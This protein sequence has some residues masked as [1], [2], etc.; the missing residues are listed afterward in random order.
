MWPCVDPRVSRRLGVALAA[1]LSLGATAL[2]ESPYLYGIHDHDPDPSEFLNRIKAGTGGVGGWVT[3]TVAVGAN[4]NDFSGA[5]FSALANAGHTIICRINYGYFPQGTIPVPALWDAFAIRCKNFVANSTGCNIWLIANETN[6]AVEWP[7]DP[8]NNRFNYISPQDYAVCFRKVY[9]AIKSVRPNDKVIVQALAPWGGPYGPGTF[10]VGGVNY[11]H[12]GVPL[13]WVQYLNQMLTAIAASGPLDGIALHIGSRGYDYEDIHST[14]KVNAGGQNLY[15]SF[16]V[17]KDWIDYGI[18]SSLYHL[19]LYV[20]ECNGLYYWK[21]GGP[22]GE[23]NPEPYKPGW[24]QEIYAEFN[25][26]NQW[27]ATN[28]RPIFRCVNL[29]RWCAYCDGWN[30]DG[31]DNPYKGQ[32]L[33]DLDAAVAQLYRWPTNVIPTNPPAAPTGLTATVGNGRV[34]LTWNPVAFANTYRVKRSTVSGGPYTVIASNLVVTTYNDVSFT[35]GTTYY[36]RVSAVN[37]LGEGPNSAQV[38]ATPTNALPDVVVT[39]ISWTPASPAVGSNVVFAATVRNQG[40]GPTPSGVILGVGFS[41]NGNLV[42]WSGTHTA[43]LAPGAS[44][45]LTANGGPGGINYWTATAGVH[46]VTAHVD[47]VNRFEEADEGNNIATTNLTI[48]APGYAINCG[49]AAAGGFSADAYWSGSANTYSN[50]TAID[51]SGVTNPAPLAV[52]QTERWGNSTYTFPALV[53]GAAYAVRLHWAEISPSVNAPGDRRFHVSINGTQVLTNFD[54]WA[55]AGA[56]FRAVTRTFTTN[57]NSA[58]QIV[59]AFTRG[60]A[61][62]AKIGGIEI[63][64]VAPAPPVL[65]PI[66]NRVINEGELL[67][68]VALAADTQPGSLITDFE[69]FTNG[70]TSVMFRHPTFSGTTSG[71]LDASPNVS[72]VSGALPPG[73]ASSRAL[74]VNWSFKAGT[75]NPWLRLTTFGASTLPNPIVDFAQTVRFDIWTDRDLR[76]GLGVRESNPTGPIGGDGGSSGP[77]E[78]VGVPSLLGSAPQP[79][80]TVPASNWVTLTFNFTNEAVSAFTG[81]GTLESTTGKGVLEHLAFVPAAGSGAYNVFLDNFAVVPPS[82]LTF[83]LSNAPG[84]ATINPTNGTFTWT[85]TEAQGPGNYTITVRV[86]KNGNASLA[87]AKTFIVTV[88]EVNQPPSLAPIPDRTVNAGATLTF[89]NTAT[90]PDL[91]PNTMTFSLDAGPSGA[92]VGASS[93]VFSWTA[94]LVEMPLTNAVTLRVSDNGAPPLSDTR[95]FNLIVV[96]P[97]R[98]V[99]AQPAGDAVVFGWQVFPGKTYRVL[100]KDD[101]HDPQW[102]VLGGDLL[103]TH[104]VLWQTN[105]ITSPAQRFFRLQQVD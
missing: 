33:A 95:S 48:Y 23:P 41:V 12:D 15:W 30:I 63:T 38:S 3:A 61:N 62:E 11:P 46:T 29:Y 102:T 14:N 27:A 99:A 1:G 84:G 35:P 34:T 85:P 40:S 18:P 52:Y 88:N 57:A 44:V 6:L 81:N 58:G 53:P 56:K 86:I 82:I 32:I 17:Y 72:A 93:G 75:T 83:S 73:N 59:L 2:A 87:D 39:G 55:A 9:N 47:D 16:Y 49:G 71:L 97:P 68:F 21:G 91:P 37:A 78:F 31:P 51:L 50:G 22:P 8:S 69:S 94:P 65:A 60:A 100:F 28:A 76:V 7:L 89:T 4:T 104:A 105:N 98:V 90:D 96:P 64:P 103:A 13:N 42:S 45:T 74:N 70:Q 26:Y 79:L 5:N 80:R 43:S 20:T 19:P 10:N 92:S 66:G 24:M 54:I 101:L 67:T 36:Y 25:R 77:I